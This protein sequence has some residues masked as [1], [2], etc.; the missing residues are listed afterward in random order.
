M[1]VVRTGDTLW[2]LAEFYLSDPFLWPEIYRINTIVVEDPHW[3]YPAEELLVPGV[4][5]VVRPPIPT[6]V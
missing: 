2:D 5:E 6:E 4:G 1:H 3:I